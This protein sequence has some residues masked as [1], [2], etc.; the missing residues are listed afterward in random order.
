MKENTL[1]HYPLS[2]IDVPTCFWQ[3]NNLDY[4]QCHSPQLTHHDLTM[5]DYS[6]FHHKHLFC[7][8]ACAKFI[9]V[10]ANHVNIIIKLQWNISCIQNIW[11][12]YPYR[13]NFLH[14]LYITVFYEEHPNS[15][16]ST[17][18]VSTES[19]TYAHLCVLYPV[20]LL[21]PAVVL[22]ICSLK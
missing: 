5:S 14:W 15:I 22:E 7:T 2:F 20:P 6:V 10:A 12:K 3:A 16:C 18:P 19:C 21:M 9:Q 13:F 8:A 17:L 1:L 11:R 4:L